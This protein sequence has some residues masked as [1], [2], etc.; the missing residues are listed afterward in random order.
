LQ[1]TDRYVAAEYNGY[2][3]LQHFYTEMGTMG[4]VDQEEYPTLSSA[5]VRDRK[6]AQIAIPLCVMHAFDDPIATWRCNAANKGLMHPENLVRTGQGNLLLL[7]T[8]RGG[9]VGWPVGWWPSGWQFMNH[10]AAGFVEAAQLAKLKE[11]RAL[12]PTSDELLSDD[13]L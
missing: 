1:E 13:A 2:D 10:A 7:L 11:R 4:D 9:H 8:Q 5:N 3:N 12:A 6:I